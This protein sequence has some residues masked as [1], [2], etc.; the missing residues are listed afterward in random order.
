MNHSH[1]LISVCLFSAFEMNFS[2]DMELG[3]QLGIYFNNDLVVELSGRSS[4]QLN[5]SRDSLQC[6][7]SSGKNMEAICIMLLVEKGKLAYE[8][9]VSKHW[10][11]FGCHGKEYLTI[12]DVL[13]H[14]GGLP[15]FVNPTNTENSKCDYRLKTEHIMN[16]EPMEKI[17]ENSFKYGDRHYHATTRGGSASL[18]RGFLSECQFN[19]LVNLISL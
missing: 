18:T 14:E 12:S 13:R 4:A 1:R 17:I 15:F 5:Y 2:K 19:R 11:E 6:V 16:V 9:L 8:D 3:A 7:F 10:P